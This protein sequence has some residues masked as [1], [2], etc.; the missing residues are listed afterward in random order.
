VLDNLGPTDP[1]STVNINSSGGD[2][3][4]KLVIEEDQDFEYEPLHDDVNH[5]YSNDYNV[6]RN[7]QQQM[8]S[9]RSTTSTTGTVTEQN[10]GLFEIPDVGKFDTFEDFFRDMFTQH[11]VGQ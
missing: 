8:S 9:L 1:S 10:N 7:Q 3:F 4:G 11:G 2:K 6:F 5:G